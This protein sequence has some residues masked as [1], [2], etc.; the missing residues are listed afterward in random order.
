LTLTVACS[1]RPPKVLLHFPLSYS[2]HL[3]CARRDRS[4]H[5]IG[6]EEAPATTS[7]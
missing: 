3:L 4:R 6:K 5:R 7:G 2:T 1:P